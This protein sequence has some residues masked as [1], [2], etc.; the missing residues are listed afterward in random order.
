MTCDWF[1]VRVVRD[2]IRSGPSDVIYCGWSANQLPVIIAQVQS[3]QVERLAFPT[4]IAY[5]RA[6]WGE[7][8]TDL[9][10]QLE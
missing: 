1:S 8:G 10:L 6:S 9:E 5:V 7:L 2:F 3:S 4:A